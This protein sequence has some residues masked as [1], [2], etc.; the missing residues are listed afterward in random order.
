MSR[1]LLA[2]TDS[3]LWGVDISPTMRQQALS[4][5]GSER[6]TAL[7]PAALDAAVGV[8]MRF[9]LA[10]SVWVL[11]H[12]PDLQAEA[13]R[14]SQSLR[15]GGVLFV[16]DMQ[17]R[18]IPT[19]DAGW[20]DDGLNVRQTLLQHFQLLNEAAF[21]APHSPSNLQKSAWMGL[22]QKKE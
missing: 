16:V 3:S 18:A 9:D 8:G 19:H 5:V 13:R 22:F 21:A 12:C 7:S 10:L 6:F 2:R 15:S 1:E 4:Y 11:Q 17:H 14:L 20:L